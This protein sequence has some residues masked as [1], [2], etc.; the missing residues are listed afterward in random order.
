MTYIHSHRR[1]LEPAQHFLFLDEYFV[2]Y[3][4]RLDSFISFRRRDFAG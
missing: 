2:T 3:F 1:L 4:L